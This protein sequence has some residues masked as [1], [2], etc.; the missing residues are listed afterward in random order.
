MKILTVNPR[1]EKATKKLVKILGI[2][3]A[4]AI[5]I[6]EQLDNPACQG[7]MVSPE[8]N[9]YVVNIN[10]LAKNSLETLAH[11]MI[12]VEQYDSGRLSIVKTIF[13]TNI[14]FE[15][16]T[17]SNIDY[18]LQPWEVEAFAKQKSLYKKIK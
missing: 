5:I 9:V 3:K 14:K 12:H 4:A 13:G 17:Y 6:T 7:K 16:K 2:K 10:P 8:P 1:L 11:E 15:G 18:N